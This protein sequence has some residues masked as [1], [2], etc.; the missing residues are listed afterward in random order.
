V[1]MSRIFIHA[2]PL[3]VSER[4]RG[5]VCGQTV[6]GILIADLHPSI[7]PR[8]QCAVLCYAALHPMSFRVR[9]Q[10][11]LR[12]LTPHT[13]THHLDDHHLNFHPHTHPHTQTHTSSFQSS[14][15]AREPANDSAEPIPPPST[16]IASIELKP[17][18]L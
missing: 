11:Y 13:V 1:L 9:H 10:A 12:P 5:Y 16:S 15:T 6:R 17:C 3:H 4:G 2:L 7:V 18:G 14:A 8:I